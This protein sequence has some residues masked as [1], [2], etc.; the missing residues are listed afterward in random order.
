MTRLRGKE[1]RKGGPPPAVKRSDQ[2]PFD[3]NNVI[4]IN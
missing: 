3:I 1:G 2:R 4:T